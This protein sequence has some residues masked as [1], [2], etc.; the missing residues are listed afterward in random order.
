MKKPRRLKR[1]IINEEVIEYVFGNSK[2]YIVRNEIPEEASIHDMYRQPACQTFE[3]VF[4]HDDFEEVEEGERI[5]VLGIEIHEK[6]CVNCDN[7]MLWN[8]EKEMQYCPMCDR[9]FETGRNIIRV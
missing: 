1:V 5:P 6:Y 7:E 9:K 3:M 2:N 8:R 4:E